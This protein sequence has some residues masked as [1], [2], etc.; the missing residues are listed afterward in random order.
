MAN[1]QTKYTW[2]PSIKRLEIN[3]LGRQYIKPNDINQ[4]FFLQEKVDGS[5]I[6]II[7]YND[8]IFAYSRN[9]II[10]KDSKSFVNFLTKNEDYFLTKMK[11][12]E[13]LNGEL[14][15]QGHIK[16]KMN[17]NIPPF[18]IFDLGKIKDIFLKEAFHQETLTQEERDIIAT[19]SS[20][21]DF[22]PVETL[23][24]TFGDGFLKT[25]NIMSIKVKPIYENQHFG[26]KEWLQY[27]DFKIDFGNGV[28]MLF[29][30]DKFEEYVANEIL[31]NDSIVFPETKD[32]EGVVI[33]S[34]D[35]S[36]R[37]K[38]VFDSFKQKMN[39][40]KSNV[41]KVLNP[42]EESIQNWINEE[43]SDRY[44]KFLDFLHWNDFEGND[45]YGIEPDEILNNIKTNPS[46][47]QKLLKHIKWFLED[48]TKEANFVG[49]SSSLKLNDDLT[50]NLQEKIVINS[51]I[52]N[53]KKNLTDFIFKRNN[54][55]Q[56]KAENTH[57]TKMKI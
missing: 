20:K 32:F 11:N 56:T 2:Y 6:S 26:D 14:M 55:E 34:S 7:K 50:I 8:E 28:E 37:I 45:F 24:N 31:K 27:T 1:P 19:Q 51:M 38:K 30:D 4:T 25:P 41:E 53:I 23:L 57:K 42:Q 16:Y 21:I 33:K 35:G 44:Q 18:V 43:M 54:T 9:Q 39:K 13:I 3:D 52:K 12:G 40:P 22:Y 17:P 36:I 10:P 5:N 29:S 48:I 15:G 47:F 46:E 49:Q